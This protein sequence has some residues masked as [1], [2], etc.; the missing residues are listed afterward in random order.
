M[1]KVFMTLSIPVPE[2]AMVLAAGRGTRMAPLG[3]DRP[4]PLL[5]VAGRSLI[6]R[7]L[8]RLAAAGVKR[9][10]VNLHH[11][12]EMI[13]GHLQNRRD[14]E[15]TFSDETGDLLE[16]GGGVAK[17]LPLLGT[18][19]FYVVN[20]DALWFDGMKDTLQRLARRFDPARMDAILL[21]NPT[22][23]AIGYPGMGD[24]VMWPDGALT[25]R[26]ETQVSPFVFTGVQILTPD[27]FAACPSGAFSLNLLYDRA[28]E[29]GRLFGLRHEGDWMCINTPT[30]LEAAD[31]ALAA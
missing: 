17:A 5:Q 25:R 21:L 14:L 8:D 23:G 27:L 16:T 6:D 22:V 12:G 2:T 9:A 7:A 18:G 29:A 24:Y 15:I 26:E 1:Q 11:K 20:A 28:E 30:G 3:D 4:K 13:R 19:A 31:Q 10:V